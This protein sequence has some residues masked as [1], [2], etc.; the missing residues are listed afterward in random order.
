MPQREWGT[1]VGAGE[2]RCLHVLSSQLEVKAG[3]EAQLSFGLFESSFPPG[4]GMPFL[5]LHRSY[6]EGFY[7]LEGEVQFQLGSEEVHAGP[8]SAILIPAGVPHCFRNVGTGDVRWLVVT[9]P[10]DAVTLIEEAGTVLPGDLDRL[11][12][13]F[14]RYDSEL[15]ER[16][17]HW[18]RPARQ[19]SASGVPQR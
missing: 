11:A 10:P 8:G 13:I 9:A 7:V 14:D 2:G 3:A 5:H 16:H 4:T 19:R 12:E 15:L 18:D 1:H 6:E 17:P